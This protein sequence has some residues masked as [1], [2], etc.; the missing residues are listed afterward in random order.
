MAEKEN[1]RE[2]VSQ[3]IRVN[4]S[5]KRI[6]LVEDNEDLS[7]LERFCAQSYLNG[8]YKIR[9][10]K[11]PKSRN[12]A[13]FLEHCENKAEREQFQSFLNEA[14]GEEERNAHLIAFRKAI[15]W[16]YE[17]HP[18]LIPASRQYRIEHESTEVVEEIDVEVEDI[19]SLD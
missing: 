19:A 13:W 7:T 12:K 5:E 10:V 1:V 11:K 4:E 15:D 9:V 18:N 16:F 8:G 2:Y 3:H 17:Q 6:Y 14:Q